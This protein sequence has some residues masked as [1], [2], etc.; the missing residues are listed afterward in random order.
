MKSQYLY[1]GSKGYYS[2][3]GV[4]AGSGTADLTATSLANSGFKIKNIAYG[5]GDAAGIQVVY[6]VYTAGSSKRG[7]S[8]TAANGHIGVNFHDMWTAG[9]LDTSDATDPYDTPANHVAGEVTLLLDEAWQASSQVVTIKDNS[10]S[11][12]TTAGALLT[13]DDTVWVNETKLHA[14]GRDEPINEVNQD[15]CVPARA[16]LGGVPMAADT[17]NGLS[18]GHS[19]HDGGMHWNGDGIDV[20]DLHFAS[21][22]SRKAADI[23]QL[24]YTAGK[25]KELMEVMQHFMNGDNYEEMITVHELDYEGQ[26]VHPALTAK[27]IKIYGC[28][29]TSTA[30]S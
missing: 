3:A 12:S 25:Y 9:V 19:S 6:R 5:A 18:G 27:G 14:D 8:Y 26:N 30:R 13:T 1:F 15:I 2:Q 16:F 23:I 20:V 24:K 11:G 22:D 7:S 21:G 10:G 28:T 29:I 4:V 17:A